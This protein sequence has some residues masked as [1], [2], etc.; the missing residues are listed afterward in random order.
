MA[1]DYSQSC[2]V[3]DIGSHCVAQAVLVLMILNPYKAGIIAKCCYACFA[4]V[5]FIT[6]K[7]Q[8]GIHIYREKSQD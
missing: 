4:I 3:L 5:C 8:W 6:E 1:N 7:A 2:S